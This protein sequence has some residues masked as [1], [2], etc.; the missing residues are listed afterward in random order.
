MYDENHAFGQIGD[1]K[2]VPLLIASDLK[3]HEDIYLK[4]RPY[5]YLSIRGDI[6]DVLGIKITDNGEGIVGIDRTCEV[7]VK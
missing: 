5:D 4:F 2:R 6:L 3:I 1:L 7:V